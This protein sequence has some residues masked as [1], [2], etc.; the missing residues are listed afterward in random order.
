MEESKS[1]A[2]TTR[3][4]P[5]IDNAHILSQTEPIVK[6]EFEKILPPCLYESK[7]LSYSSERVALP[8]HS[9]KKSVMDFT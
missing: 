3:R 1:S 2:L 6:I 8:K 9:A 7:C 4:Y 5:Y